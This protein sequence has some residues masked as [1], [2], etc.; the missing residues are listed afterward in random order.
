MD[1][2]QFRPERWLTKDGDGKLVFNA[3]A[4]PTLSFS[5]GNRG[6]WGK[7]LGYLELRIVL[8]V[9]VWSFNFEEVP[10]EIINWDT[11]DSLVTAQKDCYIRLTDAC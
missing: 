5:A 6:Y 2:G 11:Y 8:S 9:L 10:E 1:P 4:G 3:P 7:R